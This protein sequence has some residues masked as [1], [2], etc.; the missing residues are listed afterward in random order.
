MQYASK[1][2]LHNYLQKDF[3]KITWNKQKLKYVMAN[4]RGWKYNSKKLGPKFS[5][6]AHS[7]AIYTSRPL[8]NTIELELDIDIER[9]D[10]FNGTK[11]K[12][13]FEEKSI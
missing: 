4:F 5:E 12:E 1:G 2:D 9:K 8:N 13:Q 3:T 6:K 7:D 10:N 11:L